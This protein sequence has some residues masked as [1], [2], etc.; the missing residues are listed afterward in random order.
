MNEQHSNSTTQPVLEVEVEI[1]Q[2]KPEVVL[3]TEEITDRDLM[4]FLIWKKLMWKSKHKRE[5]RT[6][7]VY[8]KTEG[9]QRAL[10][11]F[12]SPEP[13]PVVDIREI[14]AAERIFNSAVHDKF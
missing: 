3:E 7:F 13:I 1:E 10:D 2:S 6:V 5:R 14:F 4:V 8:E 9:L 12:A 11:A